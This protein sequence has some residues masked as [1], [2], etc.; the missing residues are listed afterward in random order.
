MLASATGPISELVGYVRTVRGHAVSLHGD[1]DR[2]GQRYVIK[3]V[4][5]II[6]PLRIEERCRILQI[7]RQSGVKMRGYSHS[8]HRLH[9]CDASGHCILGG[10][11]GQPYHHYPNQCQYPANRPHV[12]LFI[13]RLR[14]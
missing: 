4:Y 9:G 14:I 13:F 7:N 12:H 6:A 8:G 1:Y 10:G 3:P 11:L 5:V 2:I